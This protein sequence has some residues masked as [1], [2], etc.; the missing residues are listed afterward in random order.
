MSN[1]IHPNER[2]ASDYAMHLLFLSIFL[3]I[4]LV[5]SI[6]SMPIASAQYIMTENSNQSLNN[7][8]IIIDPEVLG[9]PHDQGYLYTE[10]DITYNITENIYNIAEYDCSLTGLSHENGSMISGY[11]EEEAVYHYIQSDLF[12]GIYPLSLYCGYNITTNH[13]IINISTNISSNETSSNIYSYTE[14]YFD[15]MTVYKE[16]IIDTL[17]PLIESS[18]E[19][20]G[21]NVLDINIQ[22]MTDTQ[23][24]FADNEEEYLFNITLI[25]AFNQSSNYSINCTD[26]L[27][28]RAYHNGTIIFN[29]TTNNGTNNNTNNSSNSTNNTIDA[30]FLSISINKQN[31]NL[32]E[33]GY[34]TIN[35]NNNSNVTITICPQQQGWVQCYMTPQFINETFPKV[36]VM[37]Y[38]NKTGTYVVEAVMD[39]S[40]YTFFTNLT[41]NVVNTLRADITANKEVAAVN[42]I[43]TFNGSASGGVG[44]YNYI[45]TM[46]DG[47]KFYGKGAYKNFTVAGEFTESLFV[48]DSH[49]NNHT[50]TIDI[51]INPL[52]TLTVIVT[53][54]KTNS[55]MKDA[56]VEI[57]DAANGTTNSAGEVKFRL[58]KSRYDI[59]AS[60][61]DYGT[62][63]EDIT[64]DSDITVNLNMTFE[65]FT[66]PGITLL[67]QDRSLFSKQ[68]V[69]LKFK[70][71]D[72]T[73]LRC[74]LYMAEGNYSWFILK[75][76]GDNLLPDTE[77]TFEVDDL[78]AGDYRWRIDCID[79]NENREESEERSF[80]VSDERVTASIAN[81]D[82]A[83]TGIN[84]ALDEIESYAG[85]AAEIAEMLGIKK[86][87]RELLD[88]SNN[89]ERDIHNL[90]YRRDLDE[91]GKLEMQEKLVDEIKSLQNSIPDDI[92][93]TGS[94][95]FIKY[96]RD[97]DLQEL[98]K[99]Y[100]SIKSLNI[101][102]NAFFEATK[103]T[104]NKIVI[105]T[106]AINAMLSYPDGRSQDITMIKKEISISN[107]SYDTE[108]RGAGISFVEVIPKDI[109][110]DAKLVTIINKEY[111]VLKA[112]PI[113]EFP[114]NTKNISYYIN[115]TIDLDALEQLDTIII[116][117]NVNAI[118][119][120]TGFSIFGAESIKDIDGKT[121]MI[122]IIGILII[123]YLFST[124]DVF[125][126]VSSLLVNSKKKIS[127]IR[128][129]V[130]D[131]LD[132]IAAKDY[133]RAA[134]VYREVRLNYE[135]SPDP[136]KTEV[137]QECY[138]LCNALDAYYFNEL[139]EEFNRYTK[140]D[141]KEKALAA[142]Q[143]MEQTFEKFDETIRRDHE[144]IMKDSFN[145]ISTKNA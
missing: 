63:V 126:K 85:P 12:D 58:M 119:S 28:N 91:Q 127:Y 59:Y 55:R 80:I 99:E 134:L 23:C 48:N 95:T 116:D 139:C 82:D 40:N 140:M 92:Q 72:I 90:A 100:A 35:A 115:K 120:T 67:T 77:Y 137:Y 117:K 7:I 45:W 11:L 108:I 18:F 8:T 25:H 70:A 86:S 4:P 111:A 74:E 3:S 56:F 83:N 112:D 44:N 113:I 141:A 2:N 96:V 75:D 6:I 128:V 104:Q 64:L 130:N 68:E 26:I 31:L 53:D 32:G 43:L 54:E 97:P 144:K 39:Y 106:T 24:I 1:N 10:G 60:K 37:P 66:S 65:D 34:L 41:F 46:H 102:S 29:G 47:Q 17:A 78:T 49:G 14:E 105:S 84:R 57:E 19:G 79:G 110:A 16:L 121:A 62:V 142:Y 93:V 143:K 20:D 87:L 36:Q 33:L 122:G 125:S 30:P 69:K 109:A 132:Y 89:L 123:I 145:M 22:D 61:E 98:L 133:D 101:N 27:Q 21:G 88:K 138:D 5:I 42:E 76:Y 131:S 9:L 50:A 103:R 13:T 136:V 94:R 118:T 15:D 124:F 114:S 71:D 81:N 73:K 52:Y 38:S 107:P 135:S 51:E 129:L